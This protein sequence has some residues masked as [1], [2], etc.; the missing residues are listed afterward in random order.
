MAKT[1][2]TGIPAQPK[3]RKG[4]RKY[5]ARA[6]LSPHVEENVRAQIESGNIVKRLNLFI[7][8][9]IKMESQ[10]VTAALGLLRKTVPD[11]SA[12]EL[13][14][15]GDTLGGA[16]TNI[17]KGIDEAEAKAKSSA[18]TNVALDDT[19]KPKGMRLQ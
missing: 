18:R 6:S 7:N 15:K 1:K 12:S 16:I 5:A 8:G 2:L 19:A 13:T 9:K 4:K 10:Q 17:L 3:Q 14:H 11:L